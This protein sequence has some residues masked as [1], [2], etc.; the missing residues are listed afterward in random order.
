MRRRKRREGALETEGTRS[1]GGAKRGEVREELRE[2]EGALKARIRVGRGQHPGLK[3]PQR[4]PAAILESFQE[5]W[6]ASPLECPSHPTSQP[7]G[8]D[9]R[10][11]Q[12]TTKGLTS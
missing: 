12:L 6:P 7:E 9:P 1:G 11:H 10:A 8:V 3:T 4:G 2:W 5:A